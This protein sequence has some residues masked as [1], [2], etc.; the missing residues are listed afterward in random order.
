MHA[1]DGVVDEMPQ[2]I[3]G[4]RLKLFRLRETGILLQPLL[5]LKRPLVIPHHRETS[6]GQSVADLLEEQILLC[7]LSVTAVRSWSIDCGPDPCNR[8]TI[9]SVSPRARVVWL[10][11]LAIQN[12]SVSA[13]QLKGL[14]HC[15]NAARPENQKAPR[16][17]ADALQRVSIEHDG[18]P[19]TG[20]SSLQNTAI[21]PEYHR[22][23][24]RAPPTRHPT[25]APRGGNE[26]GAA[27]SL[28]QVK[29]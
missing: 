10:C 24:R 3:V 23:T 13:F 9:F 8:M 1:V 18:T 27:N 4:E 25:H 7:R 28:T 16:D 17:A 12:K 2:R 11:D 20:T 26:S 29:L 22:K 15:A 21:P 19:V 14:L 5:R 6:V